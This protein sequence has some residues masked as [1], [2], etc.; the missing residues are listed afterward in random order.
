MAERNLAFSAALV[1]F[2][3]GDQIGRAS[4]EKGFHLELEDGVIFFVEPN[5]DRLEWNATHQ[6][7]LA[8]DW[9]VTQEAE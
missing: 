1:R 4:W 7:I 3:K 8:D 6:D 9:T 2:T 5:G